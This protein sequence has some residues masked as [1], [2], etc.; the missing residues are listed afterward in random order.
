M[1][2][3][4]TLS[5]IASLLA[6][7]ALA[8]E[9]EDL[10]GRA[11]SADDYAGLVAEAIANTPPNN[12]ENY[13][14]G[15]A[16]LGRNAPF[17]LLVENSILEN[18]EAA[19][20]EVLVTDNAFDGQTA[21]ANA[22]S[23]LRRNVD[24]VIEF[25][26]DANFGPVI[27]QKFDAEGVP[28]TAIDIPMP[29]A[30]FMGANNSRSGFMG[31][32]YLGQAARQTWGDEAVNTGYLVVGELPQSGAIPFMRTEGQVAG[33]LA[34]HPDFPE[35]NIIRIDTTGT[36]EGGFGVMSD[37]VGRIPEGVPI[38]GVAINDQSILG[39][40]R[41]VEQ[42][43]RSEDAI[44]V[45]MGADEGAAMTETPNFLASVGYFPENY[46]NYLVPLALMELAGKDTPSAALVNHVMVTSGTVCE[47]YPDVPCAEGEEIDYSF[48]AEAFEA[49]VAEQRQNPELA[50]YQDLIQ[51][52]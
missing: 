8:I 19:G 42:A 11:F 47:F 1:T 16:N 44:F 43:G 9:P 14:F 46:G 18:A 15:F 7:S 45:G 34:E 49:H 26:T 32:L 29:G 33:F 35:D 6:S 5:I 13:V 10:D 52:E 4:K 25:Q 21:L 20:V 22:E 37:A 23:Y 36:L 40:L 39:M 31:G 24:Y 27:M 50:D 17:F 51:T 48:N 30:T 2:Y 12:G 38:M 3:T 28:V 41:A